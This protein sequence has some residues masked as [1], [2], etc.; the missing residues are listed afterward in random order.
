MTRTLAIS[1]CLSSVSAQILLQ[2]NSG[3]RKP[4]PPP[5]G[6]GRGSYDVFYGPFASWLNVK[7][8]S[9][10]GLSITAAKGDGTTDDT[11]ALQA[12]LDY[13][14]RAYR[15]ISSANCP[16]YNPATNPGGR[17]CVAGEPKSLSS[18]PQP[19][20]PATI[21]VVYLP[22][23][24]YVISSTLWVKNRSGVTVIGENPATTK[25]L[26]KGTNWLSS[27]GRGSSFSALS[28]NGGSL[29]SGTNI[30]MFIFNGGGTNAAVRRITLDGNN[31]ARIGLMFATDRQQEGQGAEFMELTDVWFQN[32]G[33]GLEGGG[34]C[35]CNDADVPVRRSHFTNITWF[36]VSTWAYNT[37]N[38]F[39]WDSTFVNV[40]YGLANFS[41]T[42]EAINNL[43]INSYFTDFFDWG[44]ENPP[45]RG[46]VSITTSD[47]GTIAGKQF[48]AGK[49]NQPT[50]SGN[51]VI[52]PNSSSTTTPYANFCGNHNTCI[53]PGVTAGGT[54]AILVDNAFYDQYFL[55]TPRLN[56][57]PIAVSTIGVGGPGLSP[58][59][60]QVED[61]YPLGSFFSG[62]VYDGL[63]TP[64]ANSE[65]PQII[66][67]GKVPPGYNP[68]NSL[69]ITTRDIQSLLKA[70]GTS[71]II[72]NIE[73]RMPQ[74]PAR[75]DPSTVALT[76][77]NVSM[78]TTALNNAIHS[79]ITNASTTK[80]NVIHFSEG[81]YESGHGPT[82]SNFQI[83]GN[84]GLAIVGDSY[85][86]TQL[87]ATSASSTSPLFLVGT[88]SSAAVQ[89]RI[90]DVT[91]ND[92]LGSGSGATQGFLAFQSG[93]TSIGQVYGDFVNATSPSQIQGAPNASGGG[94]QM[95]GFSNVKARFDF[96]ISPQI[97]SDGTGSQI[98]T[99]ANAMIQTFGNDATPNP[100]ITPYYTTN[101][102]SI[103]AHDMYTESNENGIDVRNGN[104]HIV[105][106]NQMKYVLGTYGGNY[107]HYLSNFTGFLG[108]FNVGYNYPIFNIGVPASGSS[109]AVF[110]ISANFN[111]N[112]T[113]YCSANPALLGC[114]PN[115]SYV[116][117]Y[118][119]YAPIFNG[120]NMPNQYQQ[121]SNL[122]CSTLYGLTS[123][124]TQSPSN[125]SV[126][127]SIY[128]LTY[129]PN[130]STTLSTALSASARSLTVASTANFGYLNARGYG[131]TVQID[132]E[133][134]GISPGTKG[135]TWSISSRGANGTTAAAH[136]SG[137]TVSWYSD[138]N[139]SL[140]CK[141]IPESQSTFTM[142]AAA[143]DAL[144]YRPFPEPASLS[145]SQTSIV[146]HHI[147]VNSARNFAITID[148]Y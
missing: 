102:G 22:A 93:D 29:G 87:A 77:L 71:A 145:G 128:S 124:Q 24:T 130:S 35:G 42:L 16:G 83:P 132:S 10:L 1:L 5:P 59:T 39:V 109:T 89:F 121:R 135:N 136:N 19:V 123:S 61:G 66:V 74:A 76:D 47:A 78:S 25:I 79:A 111:I 14:G 53:S 139:E 50:V 8:P 63:P 117:Q 43:F 41:G 52:A 27:H 81:I 26:W 131:I 80:P 11:A 99:D 46:N 62:N 51:I 119:A 20:F 38:Y 64:A 103:H 140:A 54:S 146:M 67:D 40:G 133:Q 12:A 88:T 58:T 6:S 98:T 65:I 96:V 116:G 122:D 95:G 118:K 23:G 127:N 113:D 120:T 3:I 129:L 138:D 104:G 72:T 137:A 49:V 147:S 84:I 48:Y 56:F 75:T 110:G 105:V 60:G 13:A 107:T 70:S 73:N 68:A 21:G 34:P 144:R 126:G 36:G 33:F 94:I 15:A 44:G 91:L 17:N 82:L 97:E 141:N 101:G 143:I 55:T 9:A 86:D 7:N 114:T 85:S 31:A 108:V 30:D 106:D 69:S 100:S 115:N 4:A 148:K 134:I 125:L 57:A 142:P 28:R 37:L 90:Q 32:M 112:P 18:N 92:Q 45:V 2:V